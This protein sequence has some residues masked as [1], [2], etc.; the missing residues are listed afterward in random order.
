MSDVTDG[1]SAPP[2]DDPAGDS[3]A[4]PPT[5]EAVV[6]PTVTAPADSATETS[7]VPASESSTTE[8]PSS[9][10]STDAPVGDSSD[11]T[12]PADTA[13]STPPTSESSAGSTSASPAPLPPVPT[14]PSGTG[15]PTPDP[16]QELAPVDPVHTT[17]AVPATDDPTRVNAGEPTSVAYRA[18]WARHAAGGN[19]NAPLVEGSPT[20]EIVDEN[21]NVIAPHS[22]YEIGPGETLDLETRNGKIRVVGV[23]RQLEGEAPEVPPAS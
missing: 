18:A 5:E 23:V 22:I 11:S 12:S 20:G 9:P 19:P 17:T 7:S 21:G 10:S 13:P 8:A 1:A 14:D 16:D 3:P 15:A 6:D 2:V 4:V